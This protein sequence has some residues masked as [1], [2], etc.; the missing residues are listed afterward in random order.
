[1]RAQ[2]IFLLI[3]S[4]RPGKMWIKESSDRGSLFTK[5]M[6]SMSVSEERILRK[7]HPVFIKE[8][9]S[10]HVPTIW[11]SGSCP[12]LLNWRLLN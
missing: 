12:N 10:N 3:I 2:K 11:I 9:E 8:R 6:I 7:K 1:M 4:V 5:E